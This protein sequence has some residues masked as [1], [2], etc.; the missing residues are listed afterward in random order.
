MTPMISFF[1]AGQSAQAYDI[2][3]KLLDEGE[4]DPL[5]DLYYGMAA[6]DTG[7][8]NLGVFALERV[9]MLE[10]DNQRARLEL[11]RGYFLLDEYVRARQEFRNV[12]NA[13]PPQGVKDTIQAFLDAIRLKERRFRS[14]ARGYAEI[15]IGHDSNANGGP[16]SRSFV[17]PVLGVLVLNPSSLAVEDN[18]MAVKLGGQVNHPFE[19]GKSLQFGVDFNQNLYSDKGKVGASRIWNMFGGFTMLRDKDNFRFNVQVNRLEVD[20]TK[21]L[22]DNRNLYA[23]NGEWRRQLDKRTELNGF[24]QL[25]MV[26]YPKQDVRNS[27]MLTVGVGANRRYNWTFK[28]EF[29]GSVYAGYERPRKDNTAARV[30]AQR[31]YGGVRAGAF[32]SVAPRVSVT[33][34][35]L[36]Q[37][38]RY[39]E[40]AAII[41]NTR[42]DWYYALDLEARW[43]IEKHWSVRGNVN[44]SRNDSNQLVNDYDRT[45]TQINLRYDFF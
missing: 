27:R 30:A 14:T 42:R 39:M 17:S 11:G 28:P 10:P 45:I 26:D 36:V 40:E 16:S 1:E 44:Y 5:F 3:V 43:L 15:G 41:G 13:D 22:E 31:N 2:A 21:N 38:N 35:A 20:Q 18:F 34:S 25:A 19:P 9:L 29:F 6:I 33:G 24:A 8:V 23:L 12:L 7:H 32:L 4:G 37:H